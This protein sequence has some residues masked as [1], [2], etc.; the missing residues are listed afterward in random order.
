MKKNNTAYMCLFIDCLKL[1]ISLIYA[2]RT[3][4]VSFIQSSFQVYR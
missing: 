2:G 1:Q 4:Q 3:A